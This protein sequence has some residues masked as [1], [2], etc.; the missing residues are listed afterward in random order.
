MAYLA[1][2]ARTVFDYPV[3]LVTLGTDYGKSWNFEIVSIILGYI[4]S[5]YRRLRRRRSRRKGGG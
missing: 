4:F 2:E 5:A 3:R 1:L